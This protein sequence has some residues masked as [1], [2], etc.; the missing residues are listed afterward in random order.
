MLSLVFH[1][2]PG[3]A[4]YSG[5]LVNIFTLTQNTFRKRRIYFDIVT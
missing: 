1:K 3:F 2:T 4:V 5:S